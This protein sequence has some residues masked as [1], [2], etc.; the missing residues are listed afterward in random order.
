MLRAIDRFLGKVGYFFALILYVAILLLLAY[1]VWPLGIG[2]G[3]VAG[4]YLSQYLG[5]G[6]IG[7]A[8]FGVIVFC[9]FGRY[10]WSMHLEEPTSAALEAFMKTG[11]FGR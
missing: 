11:K 8:I 9:L 4:A 10:C 7:T 6:L 1:G 2:I 3:L 5:T